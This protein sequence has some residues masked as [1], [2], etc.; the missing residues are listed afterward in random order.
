MCVEIKTDL[1]KTTSSTSCLAL[2]AKSQQKKNTVVKNVKYGDTIFFRL[3]LIYTVLYNICSVVP[4][5]NNKNLAVT[6]S[7]MIKIISSFT[8]P[9]LSA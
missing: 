3:Y 4:K 6:F 7:T 2:L 1:I 9:V 5:N 8:L